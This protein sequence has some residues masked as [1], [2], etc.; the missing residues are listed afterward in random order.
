MVTLIYISG[1]GLLNKGNQVLFKVDEELISCLGHAN[2][3]AFHENPNR[4]NVYTRNSLLLTLKAHNHKMYFLS[5]TKIFE[6]SM[7][8]N[9]DPDQTAP[10]GAV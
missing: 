2:V 3:H 6:A 4:T 8:N 5:S 1:R 7:T 10:V 9:V